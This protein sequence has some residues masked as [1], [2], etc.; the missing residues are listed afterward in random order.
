MGGKIA[1]VFSRFILPVGYL[2]FESCIRSRE[3]HTGMSCFV[4]PESLP[5][6]MK[7]D[8]GYTALSPPIRN[9]S[10]WALVCFLVLLGMRLEL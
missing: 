4:Q 2:S 10:Y 3:T 7:F 8:H 1:H 6:I 9:V 5:D